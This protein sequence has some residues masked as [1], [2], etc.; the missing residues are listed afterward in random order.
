MVSGCDG[1]GAA[2]GGARWRGWRLGAKVWGR[3][4]RALSLAY[5]VLLAMGVVDAAGYSVIGPVLP[6]LAADHDADV[7]LMGAL[8]ATFP[9]AMMVGFAAAALTVHTG[10]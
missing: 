5:P 9:A 7:A 6:V 4:P 3:R 2:A 1:A 10:W 8:A